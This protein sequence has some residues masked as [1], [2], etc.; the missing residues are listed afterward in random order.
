MDRQNARDL[1]ARAATATDREKIH[2][3]LEFAGVAEQF[4]TDVFDPYYDDSA[5]ENVY[6][7][8]ETAAKKVID[9]LSGAA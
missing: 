8:I 3:F 4:G 1:M 5:Y 7:V 9:R 2:V 6:E